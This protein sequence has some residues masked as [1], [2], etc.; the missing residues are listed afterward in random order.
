MGGHQ[1][2]LLF[3]QHEHNCYQE[4]AWTEQ[5]GAFPSLPHTDCKMLQE[6]YNVEPD[7]NLPFPALS[8]VAVFLPCHSAEA[9]SLTWWRKP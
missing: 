3:L 5:S 2:K 4:L 1:E 8:I 9:E 7:K 6:V